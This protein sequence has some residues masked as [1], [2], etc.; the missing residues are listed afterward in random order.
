[1]GR[2][3]VLYSQSSE[4]WLETGCRLWLA[5]NR[6]TGRCLFVGISGKRCRFG[7]FLL[8]R[9]EA[10]DVVAF[11]S[12]EQDEGKKANSIQKSPVRSV[13]YR[14]FERCGLYARL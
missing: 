2:T 13:Q 5:P 3:I 1:M 14:I 7:W 12:S 10:D 8:W 9:R 4:E 6:G 11:I